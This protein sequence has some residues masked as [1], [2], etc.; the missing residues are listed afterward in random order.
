LRSKSNELSQE[1]SA[2]ALALEFG[3]KIELAQFQRVGPKEHDE[4][5]RVSAVDGYDLHLLRHEVFFVPQPLQGESA[6]RIC[7]T[8][9]A[10]S[11][12]ECHS[13]AVSSSARY[14]DNR[15]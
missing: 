9:R 10:Q 4:N 8:V 14:N 12:P 7:S 3:Q 13:Q 11:C 1:E 15:G 6:L 2:Y 5:S